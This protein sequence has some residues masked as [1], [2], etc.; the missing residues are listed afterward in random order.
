M[1]LPILYFMIVVMLACSCGGKQEANM[2]PEQS[3]DSLVMFAGNDSVLYGLVCDGQTDTILVFL[4]IDNIGADPDTF[5]ILDA[6][7]THKI[8]GQTDIGDKVAV[9]LNEQDS[10]MADMVINMNDLFNTWC[11]QEMPSLHLRADMRGKTDKQIIEDLPDSLRKLLSTPREYSMQ[12]NND[13]SIR[14]FTN[15]RM[16]GSEGINIVNYPKMRHYREWSLMKDGRLLLKEMIPDTL[17]KLQLVGI[18][19]TSLVLLSQDSLVL[20]CN[21]KLRSY[22]AK[23]KE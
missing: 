21:D 2:A 5:I 3:T 17:G 7:K 12:I 18:D 16:M 9:V 22:Y 4:P 20:R 11:Y 13:N 19:T 23:K 8:F 6:F 15:R 1:R 14:C 10:T